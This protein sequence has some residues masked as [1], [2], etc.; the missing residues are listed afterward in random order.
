MCDLISMNS[1]LFLWFLHV[2]MKLQKATIILAMSVHMKQL[3]PTG[4]IFMKFDI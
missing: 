3:T 1:W 2:F 4:C